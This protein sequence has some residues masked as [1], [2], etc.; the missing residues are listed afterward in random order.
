MTL[1]RCFQLCQ[2][3]FLLLLFAVLAAFAIMVDIIIGAGMLLS[4][5]GVKADSDSDWE[6][7]WDW[8]TGICSTLCSASAH[9][10]R[11]SVCWLRNAHCVWHLKP[12]RVAEWVLKDANLKINALPH[13]FRVAV[14]ETEQLFQ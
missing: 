12:G 13:N 8:R 5:V 9:I 4:K 10:Y 11:V 3:F 1:L 6:W 14:E 7:E 2:V